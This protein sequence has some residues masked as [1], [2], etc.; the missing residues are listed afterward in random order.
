MLVQTHGLF[1]R[2]EDVFW[3][4]PNAAGCLLGIPAGAKS[5]GEVDFREQAG[6]YALYAD[7]KL[8]YVGQTGGQGQKLFTRLNQHRKKELAGRWNMFSGFGTRAVIKN[9]WKLKAEK[10][11]A[12]ATHQVALD[13]MEAILIHVA[14]PTLNRQ[15]GRW[16]ANVKQYIQFRDSRLG[17]SVPEMVE[18]MWKNKVDK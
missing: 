5:F 15:G 13:H 11:S 10:G 6:I 14:E 2:V 9:G 4:H 8:I 17:P 18:E 7:Y 3:G 1:W 12:T 16:G